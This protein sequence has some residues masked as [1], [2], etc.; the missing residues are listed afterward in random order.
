MASSDVR[1]NCTQGN[2]E[3]SIDSR[4]LSDVFI[5]SIKGLCPNWLAR[6]FPDPWKY[7]Y[8]RACNFYEVMDSDL[9]TIN[10][11]LGHA[12]VSHPN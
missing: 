4:H 1:G 8:C 6:A 2:L 10:L 9:E 11:S 7:F 12:G 3:G 5:Q